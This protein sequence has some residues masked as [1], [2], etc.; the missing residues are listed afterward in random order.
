MH[1]RIDTQNAILR[2]GAAPLVRVENLVHL[3]TKAIGNFS[4]V[5]IHPTSSS[6]SGHADT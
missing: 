3:Q 6:V 1:V 2:Q 4:E 5:D